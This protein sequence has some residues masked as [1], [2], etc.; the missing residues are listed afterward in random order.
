MA[1]LIIADTAAPDRHSARRYLLI[2]LAPMLCLAAA[3]FAGGLSLGPAIGDLTRIGGHSEDEFGWQE[4]DELLLPGHKKVAR[5]SLPAL[6]R[7]EATDD[8]VVFGDSF[9]AERDGKLSWLDVLQHRT[10]LSVRVIKSEG[11]Q[12]IVD[13]L[14]SESFRAKPPRA[15]IVETVERAQMIQGQGAYDPAAGC[16]RRAAPLRIAGPADAGP[17]RTEPAMRRTAFD[18]LDELYSRASLAL[19]ARMRGKQKV[20]VVNLTRSDLF[21]SSAADRLLFFSEDISRH[22]SEAVAPLSL[23]AASDQMRCGLR[24][25]ATMA[26][27]VPLWLITAPDKRTIYAPWI[28][29]PLPEKVID[30]FAIAR[31]ALGAAFIDVRKPLQDAANSGVRDVYWPND[32]HWGA[33]GHRLVGETVADAVLMRT[34]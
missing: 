16:D 19:R 12:D 8:I 2:A 25:L 23:E 28:A 20:V 21:S 34:D 11:Y 13:Y 14:G 3:M 32:T 30:V 26:G 6:L 31:D 27:E 5:S 18:N 29:D 9:S 4:P 17:L 7:G 1:D 15:V 22:R 24:R 33:R 10:G